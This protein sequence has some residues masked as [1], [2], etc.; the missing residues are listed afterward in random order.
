M[1]ERQPDPV[2]RDAGLPVLGGDAMTRVVVV[3]EGEA[4]RLTV[5]AD[6]QALAAEVQP[7]RALQLALDLMTAAL[8]RLARGL[9]G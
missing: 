1:V 2:G 3:D 8:R 6:G 9:A 7:Y 5:Y 4:I